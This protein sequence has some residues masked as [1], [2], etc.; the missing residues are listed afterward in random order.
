MKPSRT[1][2]GRS[3]LA[4]LGILCAACLLASCAKENGKRRYEEI[5][6]HAESPSTRALAWQNKARR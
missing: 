5:T 4:A 6:L 2:Y 3:F 1:G